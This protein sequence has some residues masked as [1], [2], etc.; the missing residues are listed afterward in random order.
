MK[1]ERKDKDRAVGRDEGETG[2][3]G[4][5]E[6]QQSKQGCGPHSDPDFKYGL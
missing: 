4:G 6:A 2:C 1:R 5:S 3:K